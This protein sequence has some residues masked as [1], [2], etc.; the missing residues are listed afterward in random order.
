MHASKCYVE[1]ESFIIKLCSWLVFL[2][3]LIHLSSNSAL[4]SQ[5][6]LQKSGSL[7]APVDVR[8]SYVPNTGMD[9]GRSGAEVYLEELF[10]ILSRYENFKVTL[11]PASE[12]V[13]SAHET[14]VSNA[15]NVVAFFSKSAERMFRYKFGKHPIA[16]TPLYLVADIKHDLNY[17]DAQALN[18]KSVSLFVENS[19]AKNALDAYMVENNIQMQY[20]VYGS[21]YE[22]VTSHADYHLVN[23]FYFMPNK[24]V[25]ATVGEQEMFFASTPAHQALLDKL[26]NALEQAQRYD[27]VALKKLHAAHMNKSMFAVRHSLS[28]K[29]QIILDNPRKVAEVGFLQDCPPLQY[30]NKKGE[31]DGIS[32]GVLRLLEQ[33]H[34]NPTR[35]IPYPILGNTDISKF[36]MTFSIVGDREAKSKYFYASKPYA[37]IPFSFFMRKP[38]LRPPNERTYAILDYSTVDLEVIKNHFPQWKMR[39][40]AT[41]PQVIEAF[42]SGEVDA[43]L[44]SEGGAEAIISKFGMIDNVILP[45]PLVLPLQFYLHK[46]YP[47]EAL[48]VLNTFIDKL[49]PLAV[50]EVIV[51]AESSMR[52]PTTVSGVLREHQMSFIALALLAVLGFLVAYWLRSRAEK[53]RLR[54]IINTDALTGLSTAKHALKIMNR[55]LPQA[56]PGEYMIITCDIDRFS[57]LNQVYGKE[58]GNEVLRFGARMLQQKYSD[59]DKV[60]CVARLRDDVFLVFLKTCPLDATLDTP[61]YLLDGRDGVKELL[62]SNYT[63]SISRG[64]YIIDDPTLSAET[65]IDYANTARRYGKSEH[66]FSTI[67]FDAKMRKELDAQK[68]V[69]Y[70]MEYAI[71]NNEFILHFQPKVHL[72]KKKMCG[73]EVLVRWQTHD[74]EPI[75]PDAFISVFESNAF[76][77]KLDMYVFEKVCQFIHNFRDQC[78]MPPLAL[79][80]SGISILH[81]E[82][83][84]N[85][86]KFIRMYDIEP[87]EI[88]IEITESA[89]V[90][91]SEAFIA[92]VENLE[93]LGFKIAIDDFGTGVSSLHRLSSL[94]VDVV[95]LDKAFLDDKLTQ[96]RGVVLVA[97]LISMLH[98][99]GIQVVAEG[100]ENS[101]H[102]QVLEKMGCDVAQ[103]YY[104]SKPLPEDVFLKK[105]IASRPAM[106]NYVPQEQADQALKS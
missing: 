41:S 57:L 36:D 35:L 54:A 29:E 89:L 96:R 9:N 44:L 100:V 10:K 48:N 2:C 46:K 8:I 77:A 21:Y 1:D 99:L 19:G 12:N 98:R 56:K 26:D 70:R 58:K 91:E 66:G 64:C 16:T 94:K 37:T 40:F 75:Y 43:I 13:V 88:E 79:N 62:R 103:G 67:L 73:A 87:H 45:T 80:L 22:Y 72:K 93:D 52:A 18:G 34:Q 106:R 95:K 14:I 60:E 28:A 83:Y 49:D 51:T 6:N 71:E 53:R 61:E 90:A 63:I 23:G 104:F 86:R 17:N 38:Y 101:K 39:V 32:I 105:L 5:Q 76:I 20:E 81:D 97:S 7:G 92:A 65:M 85:I 55:V 82:T 24:Q 25:A 33:M 47:V 30:V 27:A 59:K 42:A 102:V 78:I 69:I 68:Q 50:R 11:V 74:G 31:P 4:S 84:A 15:A 3:L